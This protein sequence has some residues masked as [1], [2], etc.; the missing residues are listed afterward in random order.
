MTKS[1]KDTRKTLIL[2]D[3][4]AILHRAYHA[5]P[6]FATSKGEPTGALYGVCTMLIKT[7]TDLNPDYIVACFDRAEPTYRHEAY[8]DYKGGRAKTDTDLIDQIKRS[9]DIFEA[10]DIPVYSVAGFEADDILGTIAHITKKEKDLKIIIASGD[11]DTLQLVDGDR[12]QIF[13]LKKGIKDTIMYDEKAV[14]ERFGFGPELIPDYKGL[15]GDPSDNIIGVKGVGEK[16]ATDLIL[17][18][19]SIENIYKQIKKDRTKLLEAGIKERIIGLLEENEE[20][21]EFSKMLATIRLDAPIEWKLPEKTFRETLSIDKAAKLFAELEFR[22]LTDRLRAAVG[23]GVTGSLIPEKAEEE[24][25]D[26]STLNQDDLEKAKIGLWVLDSNLTDPSLE[27]IF[28]FTKTKNFE[29]SYTIIKNEIKKRDLTEVYEN[30]ELPLIPI[31]KG[32]Q[33]HGVLVDTDA[34]DKLAKAYHKTLAKLE[35]AIYGF[36]GREFNVN[37]PKQLGEVIYDEL[38]LKPARIKKTAGGQK[39]TAEKELLK[40]KDQ[41]EIIDSI[42]QYRELQKLLS[43]YIDNLPPMLDKKSRLHARF[44]Q[45]GTT[46]GRMSS[47]DPNLQNI[48]IKTE[49]GRPIRDAFIADKERVLVAL[50]YSQIDLRVAAFLSGDEKLIDTFKSGADIH[51]RVASEVFGV[52]QKDVDKEMRRKA[53]VINFGILYGMG[54]SALKQN[55]GEDTPRKEAQEFYDTYFKKFS[56]LASYID[57]IKAETARKGY[58]ETLFGRRRYFEGLN[59]KL[60][61][62]RAAAERMA[63]NAP[64]QGTQADIMKLAM[65]AIDEEIQKSFKKKVDLI[66]QIHDEVI[67]EVDEKIAKDFAKKAKE[68]M[69][70]VLTM[71]QTKG[72]PITANASIG[73]NWG[74]MEEVS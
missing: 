62:I 43:T 35:K 38:G 40:M 46:T 24:K 33:D 41:H 73:Q 37:S 72:V 74:N 1:K 26:E 30:I 45:T 36:A 59:S 8:E 49:L 51:S 61:F 65:I 5:L 3:S 23:E 67:Y 13:T 54:V 28:T 29:N 14:R 17:N 4:H 64:I 69:E 25:V 15:R 58:T 48:P 39:S 27:D 19:G 18:F 16:T 32:M 50:D 44:I 57:R 34:L 2:L 70:G 20:E 53:K 42:L 66:L 47:Q 55:L 31:I 9:Y 6:D 11:M 12:V 68:I 52:E 60:P 56:G 21:A 71:E 10:L 63:V 7:I 22:T